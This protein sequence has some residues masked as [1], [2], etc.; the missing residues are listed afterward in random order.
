[1]GLSNFLVVQR[2]VVN[3]TKGGAVVGPT[4]VGP[5]RRETKLIRLTKLD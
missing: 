2:I 1:M 4:A 5:S 3:V